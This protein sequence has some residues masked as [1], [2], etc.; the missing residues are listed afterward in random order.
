M[1]AAHF[2][3]PIRTSSPGW[4]ATLSKAY[5]S[6]TTVF[7]LDDAQ[8]GIDPI[9]QTLLEMGRKANLSRRE[10]M[11]VLIGLG[12]SAAGAYLLIMA[13]LDP[14]PY[15]KIAFALGTGA[16]LVAGGGLT[17]IR[18]LVGHKPPNIKVTPD[19]G[20]EIRFE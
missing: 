8:L 4:L 15:S 13:I 14:E 16:V 3:L 12:I 5:R 1:N 20:F 10:W 17:A 7:L 11:A 19:G 6:K 2:S 18:V 9:N